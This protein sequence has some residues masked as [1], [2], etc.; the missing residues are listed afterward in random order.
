[1][2]GRHWIMVANSCH[3]LY[4]ADSSGRCSLLRQRYKQMMPEPLQSHPSVCGFYVIYAAFQFFK[5]RRE[6][7]TGVHNVNALSVLRNHI[8]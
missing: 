1:M 5:F 8:K 4:L 3:K 2:Q 7:I 6:E